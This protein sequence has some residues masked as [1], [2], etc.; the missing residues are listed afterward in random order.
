MRDILPLQEDTILSMLC[1]L[2]RMRRRLHIDLP[3]SVTFRRPGFDGED[4]G[5]FD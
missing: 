2:D 4:V 1:M 5:L 3:D